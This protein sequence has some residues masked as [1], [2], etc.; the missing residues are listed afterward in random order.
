M[1]GLLLAAWF[2]VV[3]DQIDGGTASVEWAPH[4]F[5]TVDAEVLP[6]DVREGDRLRVRVRRRDLR[7]VHAE[8]DAVLLSFRVRRAR[9]SSSTRTARLSTFRRVQ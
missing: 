4:V 6:S 7:V 9:L 5:G 2:V 8:H 1:R 3:V